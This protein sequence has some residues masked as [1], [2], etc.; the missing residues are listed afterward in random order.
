MDTRKINQ[1]LHQNQLQRYRV[2]VGEEFKIRLPKLPLTADTE[3]LTLVTKS[4]GSDC[5]IEH[6]EIDKGEGNILPQE[7]TG[8]ATKVGSKHYVI[9]AVDAI[10]EEEIKGIEPLD[11]E[12]EVEE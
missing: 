9:Q 8:I 11:I 5:V 7:I 3:F 2:K 10:S 4:H 12:I 1:L 6:P